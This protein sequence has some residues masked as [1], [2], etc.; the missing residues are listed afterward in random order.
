MK[1]KLYGMLAIVGISMFTVAC[2]GKETS[3]EV[4]TKALTPTV[5]P[6]ATQAVEPTTEPTAT[7]AVEPTAT[8][9][10]DRKSTR[11]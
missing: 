8:P 11:L 7:Q 10:P 4:P 1:R 9:E 2:A 5:A 6:T 3:A